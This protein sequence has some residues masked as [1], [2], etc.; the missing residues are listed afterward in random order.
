MLEGKTQ[1]RFSL[2]LISPSQAWGRERASI[3]PHSHSI[4][5]KWTSYQSIAHKKGATQDNQ[6]NLPLGVLP[7]LY[8]RGGMRRELREANQ[9]TSLVKVVILFTSSTFFLL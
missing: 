6:N 7:G 9:L 2:F 8:K 5:H 3:N 1:E 4:L